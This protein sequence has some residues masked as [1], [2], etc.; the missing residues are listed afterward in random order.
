MSILTLNE[1][2]GID[3]CE[4][5][6]IKVRG[7]DP[8]K[9]FRAQESNEFGLK[10]EF[11]PD[12]NISRSG[13]LPLWIKITSRC[14]YPF[15]SFEYRDNK[16]ININAAPTCRL[17]I[18]ASCD[19]EYGNVNNW[20][21]DE[22]LEH[23]RNFERILYMTFG[24]N[25]S[26]KYANVSKIEINSNIKVNRYNDFEQILK[27]SALNCK[28]CG[29][30]ISGTDDPDISKD[31]NAYINFAFTKANKSNKLKIYNKAYAVLKTKKIG[32]KSDIIRIEW[33]LETADSI[34][35]HLFNKHD[36]RCLNDLTDED[37]INCY[38]KLVINPILKAFD[39]YPKYEENI[40]KAEFKEAKNYN[41]VWQTLCS[42][43]NRREKDKKLIPV[44]GVSSIYRIIDTY[45]KKDR[46]RTRERFEK[47]AKLFS[48]DHLIHMQEHVDFFIS[49]LIDLQNGVINYETIEY[50]FKGTQK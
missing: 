39:Q 18:C 7:V 45:Y 33:C 28:Y 5:S 50:E 11:G 46:I 48:I 4:L 25:C 40:I 36:T 29:K 9:L 42:R 8:Q 47:Q 49:K 10:V 30:P 2:I 17:D 12:K 19:E 16:N 43:I 22:L 13:R 41:R 21:L 34:K 20:S 44:L 1:R 23:V 26:I 35:N 37:I 24:I 6:G 14:G 32:I 15:Y 27:Y 3:R 31:I 38:N